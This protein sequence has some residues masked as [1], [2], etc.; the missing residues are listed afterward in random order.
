MTLVVIQKV[1]IFNLCGIVFNK[2]S[3]LKYD[4]GECQCFFILE[5]HEESV[6]GDA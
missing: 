2:V 3:S 4:F 5:P 6:G 1:L